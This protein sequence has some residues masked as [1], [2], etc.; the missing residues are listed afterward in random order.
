MNKQTAEGISKSQSEVVHVAIRQLASKYAANPPTHKEVRA[1][2][3]KATRKSG[4]TLSAAV[5]KL[6]AP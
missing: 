5:Q 3:R 1:I 2:T 6:R 4:E